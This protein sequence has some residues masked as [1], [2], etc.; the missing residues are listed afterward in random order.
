MLEVMRFENQ[1][2][3]RMCNHCVKIHVVPVMFLSLFPRAAVQ[4]GS[5]TRLLCTK[6]NQ[7][8]NKELMSHSLQYLV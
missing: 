6:D 4:Y 2:S 5:D 1:S 8:L 7:V 3:K